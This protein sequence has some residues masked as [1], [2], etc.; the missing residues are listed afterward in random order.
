MK[1]STENVLDRGLVSQSIKAKEVLSAHKSYCDI[2]REV[3]HFDKLT[4]GYVTP[5]S[6]DSKTLFKKLYHSV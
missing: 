4:L 6:T 1:L 5:V 3:K 2:E